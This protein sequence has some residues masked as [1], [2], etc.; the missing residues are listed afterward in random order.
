MGIGILKGLFVWG[1]VA[2]G[3]I[4]PPEWRDQA[5][6]VLQQRGLDLEQ[7]YLDHLG[8]GIGNRNFKGPFCL[9]R[10]VPKNPEWGQFANSVL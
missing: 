7:A 4:T 9:D 1:I 8:M 6:V 10:K 5:A 3:S 2:E